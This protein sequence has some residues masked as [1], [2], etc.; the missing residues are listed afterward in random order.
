MK[1]RRR[2]SAPLPVFS[3]ETRTSSSAAHAVGLWNHRRTYTSGSDASCWRRVPEWLPQRRSG[4]LAGRA[5]SPWSP[6][7]RRRT[8]SLSLVRALIY[9][10]LRKLNMREWRCQTFQLSLDHS[11]LLI[12][13]WLH[14]VVRPISPPR[15]LTLRRACLAQERTFCDPWRS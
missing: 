1:H 8:I 3:V 13:E 14:G 15:P 7:A 11:L 2:P 12:H 5:R 6:C 4:M 9:S 10:S